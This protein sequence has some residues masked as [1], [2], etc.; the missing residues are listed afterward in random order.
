MCMYMYICTI[1]MSMYMYMYIYK[2]DAACI[3]WPVHITTLLYTRGILL[4]STINYK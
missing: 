2:I 1:F 3:H 4:V